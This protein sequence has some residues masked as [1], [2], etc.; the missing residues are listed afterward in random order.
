[1]GP[2]GLGRWCTTTRSPQGLRMSD[3]GMFE[4]NTKAVAAI[5]RRGTIAWTTKDSGAR[6]SFPTGM[7]R[8]TREGK[9]RFDLIPPI[10]LRRL[11]GV[12]ER[13]AAKYDDNNWKKGAPYSRF[14]DSALRHINTWV[15]NE[16]AGLAQD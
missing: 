7:V 4:R 12:Y 9:G 3:D 14:L 13:G 15:A 10:P 8:D 1:M 6:E 11:A 16:H 5:A 2:C